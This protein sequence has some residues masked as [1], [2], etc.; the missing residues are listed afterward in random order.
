M[1]QS[2][3][4]NVS[5]RYVGQELNR[6]YAVR[7]FLTVFITTRHWSQVWCSWIKI[8][9]VPVLQE[10]FSLCNRILHLCVQLGFLLSDFQAT[11]SSLTSYSSCGCN[12]TKTTD[13]LRGNL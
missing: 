10:P 12:R 6:F 3:S 9:F 4:R 5:N 7:R 2:S 13:I 11:A 8:R 1:E